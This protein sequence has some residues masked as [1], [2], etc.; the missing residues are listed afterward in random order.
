MW[1]LIASH[2]QRSL[3]EAFALQRNWAVDRA[4]QTN[5]IIFFR[6][7]LRK[8]LFSGQSFRRKCKSI[9][10][11]SFLKR[12]WSN[13]WRNRACWGPLSTPHVCGYQELQTWSQFPIQKRREAFSTRAQSQADWQMCDT[14]GWEKI[15][16]EICTS[17]STSNLSQI[18]LGMEERNRLFVSLFALE[19]MISW[20]VEDSLILVI[21]CFLLRSASKNES[22][23]IKVSIIATLEGCA[24][25]IE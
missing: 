11:A 8:A 17:D 6:G 20:R 13:W 3:V 4:D 5:L 9:H 19:E 18:F 16:Q 23:S 2:K 12:K 24:K 10:F 15:I 14:V 25:V 7:I 22:S 21:Q 1:R